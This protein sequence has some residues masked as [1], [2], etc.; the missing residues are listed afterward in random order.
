MPPTTKTKPMVLG[1]NVIADYNESTNQLILRIDLGEEGRLSS[2]GK[3]MLVA[4]S[5][6]WQSIPFGKDDYRLNLQLGIKR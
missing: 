2:T 6:G 3:M 5:G 1:N 4:S